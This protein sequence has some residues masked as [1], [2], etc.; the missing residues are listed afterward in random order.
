M[1]DFMRRR[2]EEIAE[3]KGLLAAQNFE[4]IARLGH[5]IQGVGGTFG[6]Q[7]ITDIAI[8]INEGAHHNNIVEIQKQID[9]LEK[10]VASVEIMY[11]SET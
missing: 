4:E 2:V 5:R 3:L 8:L 7:K 11:V 1:A 10:Y 9:I 6:F